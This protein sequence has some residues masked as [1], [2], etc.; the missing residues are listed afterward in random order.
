[1]LPLLKH[2]APP[3]RS[4]DSKVKSNV[5]RMPFVRN[6][7][8]K[9]PSLRSDYEEF[10]EGY[11]SSW[12]TELS[13]DAPSEGEEEEKGEGEAPHSREAAP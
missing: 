1:M 3:K 7:K 8:E 4:S 10:Q 2:L 9:H 13:L 6:Y 5:W 11:N 12:F